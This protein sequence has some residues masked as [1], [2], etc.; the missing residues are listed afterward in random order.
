MPIGVEIGRVSGRVQLVLV[1]SSFQVSMAEFLGGVISFFFFLFSG[2]FN[3]IMGPWITCLF[4][5]LETVSA[6][7][8]TT[9]TIGAESLTVH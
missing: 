8:G 9:F 2:S 6:A 1:F 4:P 3:L 7:S 5:L